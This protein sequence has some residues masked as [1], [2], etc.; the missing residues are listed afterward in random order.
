[1]D[2]GEIKRRIEAARIL[3]SIT[4]G[5]MDRRAHE[6]Y[7]LDR[8]ELSRTERGAL[9]L[10]PA[11]RLVLEKVLEVPARWFSADSI[12]EVVGLRGQDVRVTVPPLV[13][14]ARD[15]GLTDEQLRAAADLLAQALQEG[16]RA[17]SP[18]EASASSSS[19]V[20]DRRRRAAGGDVG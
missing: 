6:D 5:E 20:P 4:Q 14:K 8:Q 17:A 13:A 7:G 18:G 9:P 10:T 2:S 16:A 11:R 15:A 19:G 1:V 12:D 3:R